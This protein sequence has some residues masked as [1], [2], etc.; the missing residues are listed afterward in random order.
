MAF[1]VTEYEAFRK[2]S[3]EKIGI[4]RFSRFLLVAWP[5]AGCD[6]FK[7]SFSQAYQTANKL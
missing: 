3:P 7:A 1:S 6:A 2:C 5:M 4:K